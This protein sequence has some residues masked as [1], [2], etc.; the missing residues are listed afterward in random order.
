[1]NALGKDEKTV[2]EEFVNDPL[3]RFWFALY[4][5]ALQPSTNTSNTSRPATLHPH[6]TALGRPRSQMPTRGGLSQ[7]EIWDDSSLLQSWDEALNEYKLYHSIHVRGQTVEE[8]LESEEP[9]G[10]DDGLEGPEK[11]MAQDHED[12]G[13]QAGDGLDTSRQE[14]SR[15]F[16]AGATSQHSRASTRGPASDGALELNLPQSPVGEVQDEAL[17]NLMMSWYWAGYYTGLNEGL[18]QAK[19]KTEARAEKGKTAA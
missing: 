12:S 9:R 15:N 4:C 7:E 5:A 18:N 13:S 6:R 16:Q 1:M 17:K 8:Y 2:C 10:I 19:Q 3:P 14:E 11:H